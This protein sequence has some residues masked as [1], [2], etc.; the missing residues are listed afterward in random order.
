VGLRAALITAFASVATCASGPSTALTSQSVASQPSRVNVTVPGA[1][2]QLGGILIRPSVSGL[3]PAIIFLH[4]FQPA[5]TNGASLLAQF[6]GT[7]HCLN[8]SAPAT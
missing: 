6:G 4:G 7:S 5:G 1:G 2:I 3:R 8:Q